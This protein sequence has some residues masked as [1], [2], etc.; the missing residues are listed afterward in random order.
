MYVKSLYW[1]IATMITVGYGDI[2]PTNNAE[3]GFNIAVILVGQG[4]LAYLVGMLTNY[5]AKL[6]HTAAL[7]REK[8]ARINQFLKYRNLSSTT[9]QRI[10]EFYSVQ[11]WFATGG[12]DE[13]AILSSLPFSLRQNVALFLYA[14]LLVNVRSYGL[15]ATSYE[16]Q[17]TRHT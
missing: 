13:M 16:L 2:T 7:F 9:R 11:L 15:Q 8:L 12:S 4:L 5:V 1:A 10:S 6:D 17:A 14:Q 3:V